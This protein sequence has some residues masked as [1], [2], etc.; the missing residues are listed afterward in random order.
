MGSEAFVVTDIT[1]FGVRG[2]KTIVAIELGTAGQSLDVAV[3][4][5][6]KTTR[7]FSTSRWKSVNSTG[8]VVMLVSG[9][10]FRVRVKGDNL[11]LFDLD[12]ITVRYKY[13]DKRMLRGVYAT[14]AKVLPGSGR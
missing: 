4:Y 9:I 8:S 11:N 7:G 13:V 12:Y 3:D 2:I 6:Y 10:E 14:D 5:R 1:D